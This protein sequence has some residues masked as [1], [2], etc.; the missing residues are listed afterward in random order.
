MQKE[1]I[2]NI[3]KMLQHFFKF[4]LEY[5]IQDFLGIFSLLLEL[6]EQAF[7]WDQ[8]LKHILHD[9]W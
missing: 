6:E 9:S 7:W 5:L 3:T 2:Q 4:F 8:D 1:K